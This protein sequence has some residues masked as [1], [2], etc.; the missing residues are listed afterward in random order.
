MYS[1]SRL[2]RAVRRLFSQS[3]CYQISPQSSAISCLHGV[4]DGIPV[5]G[6]AYSPHSTSQSGDSTLRKGQPRT[7]AAR[8]FLNNPS[9]YFS[10][11]GHVSTPTEITE[12]EYH[13]FANNLLDDL[14]DKLEA[15]VE[16]L[17]LPDSDVDHASGVVTLK[18]GK[19]GTYVINKQAPNKQIWSSSP[20]S[21]PVRY[22]YV[23]GRWVY[24]RDGHDL[25]DRLEQ[26]LK[27]LCGAEL[28][29]RDQDPWAH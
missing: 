26:E 9:Q 23:D 15:Y 27:A 11:E 6:P 7:S 10:T 21:G 4:R 18:L 8:T 29:L 3:S 16:A 19:L 28:H 13:E 1:R 24:L 22:D 12:K 2:Q 14:T 20:V 17:D 25:L 5:T